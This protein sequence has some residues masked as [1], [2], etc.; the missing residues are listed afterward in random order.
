MSSVAT[1]VG[2]IRPS[3]TASLSQ[4]KQREMCFVFPWCSGFLL[5]AMADWLSILS[6]DGTETLYPSSPHELAHPQ[7]LLASLNSRDVLCLSGEQSNQ[8]LQPRTP[9]D[10][11]RANLHHI[12]SSRLAIVRIA[13]MVCIRVGDEGLRW[14]RRLVDDAVIHGALQIVQDMLG[15][16]PVSW[17]MIGDESGKNPGSIGNVWPCGDSKV[18]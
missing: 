11:P 5:T 4:N 7:D 9:G 14:V 6:T 3:W 1:K 10:C 13:S 12:A 15:S 17:A 16:L 2:A 8:G 18:H